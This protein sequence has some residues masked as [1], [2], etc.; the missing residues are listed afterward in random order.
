MFDLYNKESG[1]KRRSDGGKEKKTNIQAMTPRMMAE[2]FAHTVDP[3][4]PDISYVY[5]AYVYIYHMYIYILYIGYPKLKIV[6][7]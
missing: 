5:I 4:Y 1:R 7:G 2:G 6:F 3:S